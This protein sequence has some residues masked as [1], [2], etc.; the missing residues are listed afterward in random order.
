[1]GKKLFAI[2]VASVLTAQTVFATNISGVSGT[3]GVYNINPETIKGTTGF[4]HYQNFHLSESDI[5]NLVLKYGAKDL[6]TFINL[7]DNKVNIQGIL[8]T[9][10]NGQFAPGHAVFISPN[11]MVVGRNGVINVGSLSVLTPTNENYNK[12]LKNPTGLELKDLQKETNGEI[13]VKGKI[14]TRGDVNLRGSKISLPETSVIMN[15]VKDNSVITSQS[16]I[17]D[18]IFNSLVNTQNLNV[19]DKVLTRNNGKIVLISNSADGAINARGEIYNLNKGT[20]SIV[21]KGSGQLKVTGQVHNAEGNLTIQNTKGDTYINGDVINSKGSL[22]VSGNGVKI[23]SNANVIA[24]S[25][26]LRVE[27]NGDAGLAIYGNVLGLDKNTVVKN[28]KGQFYIAGNI[29]YKGGDNFQIINDAQ[30]NSSM[31]I[32]KTGKI[33]SSRNLYIR[34]KADGGLFVNGDVNSKNDL[35]LDN[36]NGDLII[37]NK[38]S[39]S[40]GNLSLA[41]TGNKLGISSKGSVTSQGGK[42][43]LQNTGKDGMAIYGNVENDGTVTAI[44]NKNGQLYIDGNITAKAGNLGIVNEGKSAF[45]SKNANIVNTN[46]KTNIINTGKDGMKA[47]GTIRTNNELNIYNDNGQLYVDG[48]VVGNNSDV[49]ILSRKNS[50]GVYVKETAHIT[51]LPRIEADKVGNVTIKDTAKAGGS[52][53]IIRGNVDGYNDVNIGSTN[54]NVYTSGKVHALTNVNYIGKA[55]DGK[56][57]FTKDAVVNADGKVNYELE[58]GSQ[59]YYLPQYYR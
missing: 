24:N 7:V 58:N 48:H 57:S 1:M 50:T 56:V 53:V 37:N 36:R 43:I 12:L 16:Q 25:G 54:N 26:G 41:N 19:T 42:L 3:N 32:A 39:N 5:A 44:K 11:G 22:S 49:N 14:F 10:R 20:T 38:V 40:N 35:V 52:G 18:I 21:N 51:N 33:N 59:V 23:G 8:N 9:T 15:G 31:M 6:G 55:A 34:N 27:N 4:R 28:N 30:E 47:Y 13:L 2:I 29:E 46:G 17:N 45:I